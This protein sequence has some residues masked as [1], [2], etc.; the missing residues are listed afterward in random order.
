MLPHLRACCASTRREQLDAAVGREH[1]VVRLVEADHVVGRRQQRE[2]PP[3]LLGVDRLVRDAGSRHGLAE[4]GEIRRVG[5]AEIE[6]SALHEQWFPRL[7]AE[8]APEREGGAG[9]RDVVLALVGQPDHP[10]RPV[11][12]TVLMPD[13]ARLEQQ[14]S[15]AVAGEV[16]GGRE[17][18]QAASHDDDLSSLL[19]R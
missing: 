18:H 2:P 17:P 12:A 14:H 9:E 19:V 16:V 1:R 15:P 4:R 11:R 10:G 3:D 5:R 13:A 6:P 8:S 7:L